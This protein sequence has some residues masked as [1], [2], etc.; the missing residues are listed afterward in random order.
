MKCLAFKNAVCSLFI[1]IEFYHKSCHVFGGVHIVCVYTIYFG[2]LFA[3]YVC[4]WLVLQI[5]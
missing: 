3:L 5:V 4:K 2:I 1:G